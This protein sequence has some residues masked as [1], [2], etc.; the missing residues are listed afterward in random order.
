MRASA[1]AWRRA[2]ARRRQDLL[3]KVRAPLFVFILAEE[4]TRSFLP[5]FIGDLLVPAAWLSPQIVV[6]LPIALFMLIVAVG[7]PYLG[8][9]CE[10]VGHRRHADPGAA[11]AAVGFLATAMSHQVLDL[12]LWRSFCAFGYAMVF[13]AGQA[14]VLDHAAPHTPG[15]QLRDVRRRHHGGHGLRPVDRRH[16]GRQHR[17][18]ADL[19]H[20]RAAGRRFAVRDPAAA[21]QPPG[22]VAGRPAARV[23]R[24]AEIGALL[25][26]G[27][28]MTVTGLAAMPA[29]MLLTGMCFYLMPLYVL[30]SAARRRWPAAS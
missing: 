12:L 7:Q 28:F 4:L 23:P 5:G 17:R 6:G 11:I 1:S 19:R 8:A 14:Y 24:L 13:V 16:P 21:G 2:Q 10:R 30:S 3:P 27:R 20:R 9:L 15:A 26:N 22:H 29:K 18:A 25:R